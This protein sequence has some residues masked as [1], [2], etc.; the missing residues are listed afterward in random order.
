MK[1]FVGLFLSG[2]STVCLTWACSSEEPEVPDDG[3]NNTGNRGGTG[4][5]QGGASAAGGKSGS[6]TGGSAGSAMS[7]TPPLSLCSGGCVN[8]QGNSSNCGTC[9]NVCPAATPACSAGVCATSCGTGLTMCPTGCANTMTET[10]NCGTCGNA[11][12]NGQSC[13]AGVCSGGCGVGT[14]FCAATASCVA[15]GMCSGAGG[16]G[17]TTSVGG[18]SGS[19]SVG[20]SA[21][22]TGG[23]GGSAGSSNG[24]EPAGYWKFGD[25]HGCAW[26]GVGTDGTSTIM[27]MDFI[28]KE[29]TAGYCVSGSVGA[30][31]EYKSVAL[32]GFN[33]GEPP[34]AT[35]AYKPVD[36]T[37]PGPPGVTKLETG[38]AVDFVKKGANTGFTLRIQLQGPNGHKAGP[39]GEADRWCATITEVQGKVFVPYTSFTPKCWE[40]TDA[41]KGTPYA[42]QAI[43]AVV[44]L[45]PGAPTAT[46]YDFCINGVAY[47][48]VPEDAPDGPETGGDQMGNVGAANNDDLD[49][50]RKKVSFGGED[51]IIQNNNWGNP[52][53][54]DCILSFLNN[55]FTVTTCTGSGASAPA[56][57]PSIYQGNNGNT[58]NGVLSTKSTD[59]MPIQIN[60]IGSIP[61]SFRYSG[62][63][64][65]YNATYDIWFANSPP[66]GEYKDGIDGFAMVWLRDPGDKQPIGT[67]QGSVMIGGQSWNV[68]V[69]PRGDGPE[70]Y[71]DAPVVSFVNPTQDDNSRAQSFVNKNLL[72]F[73]NAATMSNRG[74][75]P[76]MYLTDIFAGFEIWNG[77]AGLK[78]DEFT[79]KVTPN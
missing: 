39:E 54:S 71:N 44:F 17:G 51:Y 62:G 27:P 63:S 78:V 69:G 31:P 42:S 29:P 5:G 7:C 79:A 28:A 16:A 34:P 18:A 15:V 24:V 37:M 38:I 70:G 67:Q 30:E 9:G 56:A 53:G 55:S 52:A 60:Q 12:T 59:E 65:S 64:G 3:N 13:V 33:V 49:F 4:Q 48:N 35:C 45:V 74:L 40:M 19:S 11:C 41:M 20:G 50:D 43:S 21:G 46:P 36:V 77:G 8:T 76:T 47:G 68:W 75:T 14:E 23:T 26:T 2:L 57:F 1:R 72:E 58:A 22:M 25:W 32:M 73:I 6:G 66:T 61:T 10:A